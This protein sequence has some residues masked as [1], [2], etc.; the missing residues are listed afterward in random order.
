MLTPRR[1]QQLVDQGVIPKV[2][3]GKFDAVAAIQGYVRFLQERTNGHSASPADYH[4]EKSR[5]TKAQ[6]DLAELELAKARGEVA[7]LEDVERAWSRTFAVLRTNV[8][9]V[10][11][12]VATQL[13]GETSEQ[14][15][16]A[17]LR[18]E[19]VEAL[20]RTADAEPE[21]DDAD[22]ADDDE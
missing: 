19:L 3:H 4:A 11:Q 1:V 13:L 12:R 5:L 6:A 14:R 9:N 8:M 20:E 15:F 2:K 22:D 18:A 17:V 16:K 21:P 10:P 7:P